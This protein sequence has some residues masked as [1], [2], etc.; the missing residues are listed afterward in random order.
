MDNRDKEDVISN[1]CVTFIVLG[2]ISLVT[3]IV[4]LT[5]IFGA[6][7]LLFGSL[8][9]MVFGALAGLYILNQK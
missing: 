3:F 8:I 6:Y 1:I 2:I 5:I 9:V 4:A 7:G